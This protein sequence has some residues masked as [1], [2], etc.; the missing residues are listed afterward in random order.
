MRNLQFPWRHHFALTACA[1]A[2]VALGA[3]ALFV[4]RTIATTL[5]ALAGLVLLSYWGLQEVRTQ[6]WTAFN[7]KKA[8]STE[9]FSILEAAVDLPPYRPRWVP[10]HYWNAEVLSKL[11]RDVTEQGRIEV[12]PPRRARTIEYALPPTGS[13]TI[14]LPQLYFPGWIAVS[15]RGKLMAIA[16]DPQSGLVSVRLDEE[17]SG[18]TLIRQPL[19]SEVAGWRVAAATLLAVAA[20]C[21]IYLLY[22]RLVARKRRTLCGE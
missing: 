11:S 16:P 1:A 9:R 17:T 5:A 20:T 14:S 10:R 2:L 15:D 22:R 7:N 3:P 19:A 18:I 21:L 4:R 8:L 12:L 6:Y 13:G